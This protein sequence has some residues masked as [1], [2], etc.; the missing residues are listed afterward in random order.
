MKVGYIRVSTVEQNLA[1]QKDAM[2]RA[3]VERVFQEKRSGT[4][5]NRPVLK[6]C[7][8]FLREGDELVVTRADR[9]ARSTRHLLNVLHDLS[10]KG[11]KVT[12]LEQ[13]E[14][15][16]GTPQAKLMLGIL[17][18][19]AAFENDL[20]A[21][22]QREGIK[23]AMERGVKFGRE[24]K[25]TDEMIAEIKVMRA[26][27]KS[28]REVMEATGLSKSSVIRAQRSPEPQRAA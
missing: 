11:V 5:D 19:V 7:L 8:D 21:A 20:R 2:K 13:P 23:A 18:S 25:L 26:Q 4:D 3:G 14:L 1:A 15:N 6:Q 24:A 17:A 16:S 10:E 12:F 27:G 9:L 22:R 28:I